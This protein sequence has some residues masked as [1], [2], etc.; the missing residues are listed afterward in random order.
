M[1]LKL[2]ALNHLDTLA[3]LRHEWKLLSHGLSSSSRSSIHSQSSS[4]GT[5]GTNPAIQG[6]PTIFPS[7]ASSVTYNLTS[8]PYIVRPFAWEYLPDGGMA[9][10]YCD[11]CTHMT[12]REMFL[13]DIRPLT[14]G[15]NNLEGLRSPSRPVAKPRTQSDLIKI[16]SVFSSVVHV[17][18]VAHKAGITHNNVNTFSILVVKNPSGNAPK[19]SAANSI[20][21]KLGGWHLA[22][23][24]EREDP[25]RGTDGS[26]LRGQNPAPLQYI[27]PECTGRMNR[28]I[29]Y[30]ADFYSL[31]VSLYELVVGFLPFRSTDPLELIHQHI[32]QPPVPPTEMNASIPLAVSTVIMKLLQKNAEDRYQIASGLKADID[33]LI[34][35]M[36][37]GRSL[38]GMRVG[39][40]DTTSQFVI[41]EKL[42]GREDAVEKLK[43]AYARCSVQGCTMVVVRGGS[44][45]GKS[46][47]VNEIQRPVAENR[48]YFTAGKFDQ[49]QRGFTFFTLV[50]A[51]QDLVRQ[52]LSEP[53]QSL[54]RWRTDTIKALDG[55]AAALVDVIPEL[56]LLLGAD[57]KFE[58]LATLGPTERENRF[59]EVIGR[60]LAVFGRK[61]LV[62]FLDDLQW[63]SQSELSLIVGIADEANRR[64]REWRGGVYST[65]SGPKGKWNTKQKRKPV[66]WGLTPFQIHLTYGM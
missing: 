50:Q 37:E 24:L 33:T 1:V 28:S 35:R 61:G 63:C 12:V 19:H 59:R 51:L 41:T 54:S 10:V 2:C 65:N 60:F 42:Y 29:D 15:I 23:R 44:G 66:A 7:N 21:G 49:Y 64:M 9:L 39:E 40:L 11:E 48:G 6:G 34:R 27:A 32:A 58:P 20:M 56:K 17:L 62:L 8:L 30:R 26:M 14:L 47:L 53:P 36:S 57:Y 31:G 45:V 18:S 52:V 22:S 43:A 5:N 13:P 3:R 55:D 4:T 25:G 46:R 16:L 38:E